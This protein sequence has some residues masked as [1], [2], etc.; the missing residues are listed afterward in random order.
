MVLSFTEK[1]FAISLERTVFYEAKGR[2]IY[3]LKFEK[4]GIVY[5]SL[6]IYL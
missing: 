2:S 1:Y 3:H 6:G 5:D 4:G